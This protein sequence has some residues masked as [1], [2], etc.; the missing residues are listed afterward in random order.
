MITEMCK[1][2]LTLA[3]KTQI[4][5]C[6]EGAVLLAHFSTTNP[7]LFYVIFMG[8]INNLG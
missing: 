2:K 4:V 8:V 5:S 6:Q 1:G 7:L 3:I